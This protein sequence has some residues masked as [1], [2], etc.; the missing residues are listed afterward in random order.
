[1]VEFAH[2]LVA[3]VGGQA[4]ILDLGCGPGWHL[5]ML[6]DAPVGLD[7]SLSMLRLAEL[8]NRSHPSP[9]VQADMAHLPFDRAAFDGVWASRT[10]VH[11]NRTEVPAALAELHRITAPGA[12][13]AV[14]VLASY[15]DAAGP[16][17]RQLPED[18]LPGRSFSFWHVDQLRDVV[19][20]AG[21]DLLSLDVTGSG[22]IK[23]LAKR[24]HT[25]PDFVSADMS[26]LICGLNPS[27]ASA[28]AG[29]GFFRAGNRF[30]PAALNAG[31]VTV[32][33]SPLHALLTHGV[34]MT[35][36]AKRTTRR[37]DELRPDEYAAGVERVARLATWLQPGAICMV[38]LA[39][40]RSAVDHKAQR[41][42]QPES[43]GGRPVYV[44][45]ST[46]GLNAHDTIATLTDHLLAANAGPDGHNS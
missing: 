5:P 32:D 3:A 23:I 7:L 2:D 29:V 15:D 44:M 45:P 42:W 1:M 17:L 9:L 41:G 25:L 31:L 13:I 20:G 22:Q 14:V 19:T 35:D 33:R 24:S 39:G 8:R 21:F 40:W 6:G 30:W 26:L 37:A 12:V 43:L 28:D 11:L 18:R 27:P 38:G 4:R 10:L 34:G 16:D 46:S 36:L